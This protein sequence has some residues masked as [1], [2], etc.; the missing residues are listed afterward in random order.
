MNLRELAGTD[1]AYWTINREERNV[2]ALLYA[3]L[4]QGDNLECFLREV[5]PDLP[6]DPDQIAVYVEYAFLRDLW[7]VLPRADTRRR[8]FILAKLDTADV[9]ALADA[10]PGTWNSHFGGTSTKYWQSPS[11]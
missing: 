11:R 10:D 3:A 5:A 1:A 9:R 8:D 4:L 2:V 7:N 6:V